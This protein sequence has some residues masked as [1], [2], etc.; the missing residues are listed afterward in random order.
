VSIRESEGERA[1]KDEEDEE[2]EEQK[3]VVYVGEKYL[4]NRKYT[5][6]QKNVS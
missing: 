2:E 1:K 3:N 4:Q 5:G 6:R